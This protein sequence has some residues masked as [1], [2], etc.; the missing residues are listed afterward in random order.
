MLHGVFAAASPREKTLMNQIGR[1]IETL[2]V[3]SRWL[4]TPFLLG[5]I[6]GVVA[7]LYTFIAKLVAYIMLLGTSP[8]EEV[9]VGIL[10]LVEISLTANLLVILICSGYAHFVA[11][12][13]PANQ[14]N[15]PNG[16]VGI[17]FSGVKQ[18]LLGSILAIAAISVLD[19]FVD[20]NRSADTVK[21]GWVVGIFLSLAVA[22][23]MLAIAD[24][25]RERD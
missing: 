15:L 24:W 3:Q 14:G 18:R 5:L 25:L 17:G 21:L 6:I 10:K 16:L 11:K 22:M 13:H 9:I 12:I 7:L 23:L 20:I 19:W 4:L 2:I 8:A 1:V